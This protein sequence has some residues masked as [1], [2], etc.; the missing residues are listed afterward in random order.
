VRV[1][2]RAYLDMWTRY[3]TEENAPLRLH[4]GGIQKMPGWKILNV[5]PGPTVD[6]VGDCT[7]LSQFTDASVEEIYASHVLEHLGYQEQ[8]PR[9]LSEFHRVLKS[10]GRAKISVPDFEVLCRLFLDPRH[11]VD[12]RMHIMRM[13]FGGQVD[14]HDFHQVGLTFDILGEFV[15]R[16]GFSRVEKTGEFGLFNDTSSMRFSGTPISLNVIAHK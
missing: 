5:Q 1:L 9:A 14:A 2:E 11:G 16:A 4:I 13:A 8:L 3:E 7:D 6:Y 15:K 12:D 10:G